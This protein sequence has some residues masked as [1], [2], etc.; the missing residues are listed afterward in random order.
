MLAPFL[1]LLPLPQIKLALI[2]LAVVGTLGT[3]SGCKVRSMVVDWQQRKS[4]QAAIGGLKTALQERDAKAKAEQ[5]RASQRAA[6]HDKLTE[7]LRELRRGL[8]HVN[9]P[10]VVTMAGPAA[11]V[12]GPRQC[13]PR[14]PVE[15][16]RLLRAALERGDRAGEPPDPA[17]R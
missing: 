17:K 9:T 15:R 5:Q 13:D 11:A 1:A 14:I 7:D 12:P 4:D 8:A 16:L 6:A 2:A 10:V 3:M